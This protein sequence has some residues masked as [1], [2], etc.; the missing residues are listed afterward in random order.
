MELG[1]G[2]PRA[3][4]GHG[5]AAGVVDVLRRGGRRTAGRSR[6]RRARPSWPTTAG[7]RRGRRRPARPA[8]RSA[9]R[10]AEQHLDA[11]LGQQTGEGVD[12]RPAPPST[13]GRPTAC[14]VN[15]I[16]GSISPPVAWS[17]DSPAC[18]SQGAHSW[19]TLV[20][21]EPLAH[22]PA[23]A[24][25]GH[26]EQLGEVG[27]P[28]PRSAPRPSRAASVPPSREPSAPNTCGAQALELAQHRG[29]G[30]G[31][32]GVGEGGRGGRRVAVGDDGAALGHRRGDRALGVAVT[33]GRAGAGRRRGRRRRRRP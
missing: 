31:V 23:P 2:T 12:E 28:S 16:T 7:R 22:Q 26:P 8:P 4:P 24:L 10:R 29:V 32:G 14:I 25:G 13:T 19:S 17:G 6:S 20:P 15:A 30:R 9:R 3:V 18:R 11:A 1:G 5:A 21:G 33:P 27:P